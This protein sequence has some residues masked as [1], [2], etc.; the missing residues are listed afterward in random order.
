MSNPAKRSRHEDGDAD[1]GPEAKKARLMTSV[2]V[3]GGR[4]DEDEAE[5][6]LLLFVFSSLLF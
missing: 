6:G 5:Q 1:E 4:E 2:D 3:V